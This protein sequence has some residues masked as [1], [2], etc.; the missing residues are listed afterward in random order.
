MV[1]FTPVKNP[2]FVFENRNTFPLKEKIR[3]KV[4]NKKIG[5]IKEN[6][7]KKDH[8]IAQEKKQVFFLIFF[9]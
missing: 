4:R 8:A 3:E 7:Q 1:N 9:L 5:K 6:T 2:Q